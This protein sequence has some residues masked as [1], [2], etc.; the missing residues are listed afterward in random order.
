MVTRI[1]TS[2]AVVLV[3]CLVVLPVVGRA[4]T[5]PETS[6]RDQGR[7][8]TRARQVL[9]SPDAGP[10]LRLELPAGVRLT[11]TGMQQAPAASRGPFWTRTK[12]L[13]A[14]G[15]VLVGV[16]LVSEIKESCREQGPRCFD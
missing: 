12:I 7:L 8:V 5:R 4:Q 15:L 9:A 1:R 11:A 2:V 6:R 10:R 13:V 3:A 14:V 16:W